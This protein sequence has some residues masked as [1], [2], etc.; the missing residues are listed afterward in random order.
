TASY[1]VETARADQPATNRNAVE[2]WRCAVEGQ[3]Q[4]AVAAG[5]FDSYKIVCRIDGDPLGTKQSRTWY[6]APAVGHYVRFIDNAA[7]PAN[8][9]TGTRSRDLVAVSPGTNGW[10]SEARTGL[11]WAVSH[12]LEAEPDG[13]PVRWESS[14]VAARFVIEPADPVEAGH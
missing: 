11:E 10:P 3:E 8:G 1:T 4:T 7:V 14:A 5:T 6:Y 9:V 13:Q 12:A 2:H